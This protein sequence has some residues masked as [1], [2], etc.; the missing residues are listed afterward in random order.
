MKRSFIAAAVL[1]LAACAAPPMA[2]DSLDGRAG[3]AVQEITLARQ[4]LTELAKEGKITWAQDDLAQATLT[5]IRNRIERA[6]TLNATDPA[7]AAR[8]LA[9][10]LNEWAAYQGAKK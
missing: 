2:Q 3:K 1:A 10:V 7:Q 5:S 6:Q 9:D 4:A 8:L